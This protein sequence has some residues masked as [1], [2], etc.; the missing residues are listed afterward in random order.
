MY[1]DTHTGTRLIKL[2]TG[3]IYNATNWHPMYTLTETKVSLGERSFQYIGPVLWNSFPL[4]MRSI[5]LHSLL[6]SQN[7][8][9]IS[10]TLHTYLSF[11]QSITSNACICSV[12]ARARARVCMC[13]ISVSLYICKRSGLLR[14]GS[15]E[16]I[17]YYYKLAPDLCGYEQAQDL[18]FKQARVIQC[19]RHRIGRVKCQRDEVRPLLCGATVQL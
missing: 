12:R 7:G 15:P 19:Y 8:K 6:F 13:V 9:P 14:D 5:H 16:I 10:S 18:L 2:Q 11:Y 3:A 17:Y 4:S 1:K